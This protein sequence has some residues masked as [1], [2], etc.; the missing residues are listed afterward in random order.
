MKQGNRISEAISAAAVR[1]AL[2]IMKK[3]YAQRLSAAKVK[4]ASSPNA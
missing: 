2:Q 4:P 3:R 1:P